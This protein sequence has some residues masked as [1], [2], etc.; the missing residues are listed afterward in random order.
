[1]ALSHSALASVLLPLFFY[2][3]CPSSTFLLLPAALLRTPALLSA[4][5]LRI[6]ER[7]WKYV[8]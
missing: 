8:Q 2:F 7:K 1:M 5:L 4:V 3:H 6:S